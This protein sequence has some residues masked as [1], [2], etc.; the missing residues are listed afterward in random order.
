[1]KWTT[2]PTMAF[3]TETTGI[4]VFED[5]IVCA[6]IVMFAPK[7]ADPRVKTWL[8]NPGDDVDIPI[9]ATGV[10]GITTEQVRAEGQEP[11]K[12]LEEIAALLVWSLSRGI[13]VV[14]FNAAYDLS[15]TEAECRRHGVLGLED[16]L[17]YEEVRPIID[18][19]VLDGQTFRKMDD[20]PTEDNPEARLCPCGCGA[21]RKNLS[22]SCDHYG[23]ELTAAHDAAADAV[24]ADALWRAIVGK[25]PGRFGRYTLTALH[26]AQRVW[27]AERMDWMRAKFDEEGKP[28]DGFDPEWPIRRRPMHAELDELRGRAVETAEPQGALL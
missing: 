16:R 14:A 26:K 22:M 4:D 27:R 28:H 7:V 18:P 21:T 20:A 13:P 10:H 1:M 17:G 19:Y 3:D 23:V 8:I 2:Q 12:V 5:R 11:A 6:A 24:A 25:N 15:L 9:E